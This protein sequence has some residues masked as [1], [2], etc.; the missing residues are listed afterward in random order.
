MEFNERKRLSSPR[1]RADLFAVLV[2]L[3]VLVG[4]EGESTADE[5]DRVQTD[6]ERSGLCSWGRARVGGAGLGGGVARLVG[7]VS[8]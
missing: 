2:G 4:T 1:S 3:E 7:V 5:E 8:D 6:P